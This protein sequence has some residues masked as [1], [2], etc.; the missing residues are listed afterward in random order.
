M[1]KKK[2]TNG[3][4][5]IC[6]WLSSASEAWAIALWKLT[7]NKLYMYNIGD[8]RLQL[9]ILILTSEYYI[10]TTLPLA[11]FYLF[12][13]YSKYIYIYRERERERVEYCH[14]GND[15]KLKHT[16]MSYDVQL[17]NRQ[18]FYIGV[19]MGPRSQVILLTLGNK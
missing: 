18:I 15:W 9:F 14:I 17:G 3:P 11:V 13:V 19:S 8:L 12:C 6:Q 7:L 5:L 10:C 16:S 4:S 2:K 1:R